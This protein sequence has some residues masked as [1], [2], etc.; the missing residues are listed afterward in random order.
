M[1]YL[2]YLLP[3]IGIIIFFYV[4]NKKLEEKK[5]IEH[6]NW[7]ESLSEEERI[8]IEY[9]NWEKENLPPSRN[10]KEI[11]LVKK[12]SEGAEL[13]PLE[14]RIVNERNKRE[15]EQDK[16]R[17]EEYEERKKKEWDIRQSLLRRFQPEEVNKILKGILWVGMTKEMLHEIKGSPDD[18]SENVSKGKVK[19]KFFYGKSTNRLGNDSF[20]F[21]VSLEDDLVVG[22]K[23]RVN[24]GTRDF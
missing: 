14:Y 8:E 1:E 13:T 3:I 5:R 15:K 7:W 10:S 19:K 4:R 6:L 21:E 11:E 12:H 16:K 18:I 2:I 17:W 20:D 24:R 22:W 9:Q 23:D